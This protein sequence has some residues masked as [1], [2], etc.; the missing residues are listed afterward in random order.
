MI[1]ENAI[2]KF[3]NIGNVIAKNIPAISKNFQVFL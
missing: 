2:P 3:V 1:D